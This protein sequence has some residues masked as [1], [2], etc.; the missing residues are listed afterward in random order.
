MFKSQKVSSGS[1]STDLWITRW[2][3]GRWSGPER[4]SW[5]RSEWPECGTPSSHSSSSLPQQKLQKQTSTVVVTGFLQCCVI[6]MKNFPV[7]VSQI[8]GFLVIFRYRSS[9]G[10]QGP[11]CFSPFS[12]L[13]A[14]LSKLYHRHIL[15]NSPKCARLRSEWSY[16]SIKICFLSA[17]LWT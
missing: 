5:R 17:F 7:K 4:T 1:I 14:S 2:H 12:F 8:W 16:V 9:P 6:Q 13:F 10:M 15:K 11:E 3:Q